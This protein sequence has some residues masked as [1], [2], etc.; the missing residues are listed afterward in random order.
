MYLAAPRSAHTCGDTSFEAR[1]GHGSMESPRQPLA[2]LT[3]NTLVAPTSSQEGAM[4]AP[5][6]KVKSRTAVCMYGTV[7]DKSLLDAVSKSADCMIRLG[8][9]GPGRYQVASGVA[10]LQALGYGVD[11][12]GA[13]T[14]NPQAGAISRRLAELESALQ[15][16]QVGVVVDLKDM[17]FRTGPASSL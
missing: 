12:R 11:S 8:H 9:A 13:A 16:E 4:P 15:V 17:P 3:P 10:A 6:P 7:D 5:N 14:Y 1:I 2:P